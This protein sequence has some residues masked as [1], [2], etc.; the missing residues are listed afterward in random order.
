VRELSLKDVLD[1]LKTVFSTATED[2]KN[3]RTTAQWLLVLYHCLN[4]YSLQQEEQLLKQLKQL[5]FIPI[6]RYGKKEMVSL[7]KCN[8]FFPTSK[9]VNPTIK[10]SKNKIFSLIERELNLLDVESLLCLDQLKN[11]QVV[12]L[13]KNLGVKQIEPKEVIE[14]HIIDAFM[15]NQSSEE[16]LILY[17]IYI[18]ECFNSLSQSNLDTL[19]DHMLLMTNKG[20]KRLSETIFLTPTYGNKYDLKLIFPS[21]DWCLIDSIYFKRSIELKSADIDTCES[22]SKTKQNKQQQHQQNLNTKTDQNQFML[23]W[24]K[25]LICLG[26]TDIFTPK[27]VQKKLKSSELNDTIYSAHAELLPIITDDE[28]YVFNDFE[29]HVFSYYMSLVDKIDN[30]VPRPLIEQLT[31]LYR[32]IEENWDLGFKLN[33][34]KYVSVHVE[35]IKQQTQSKILNGSKFVKERFCETIY[36][37]NLKTKKWICA[38]SSEYSDV[39]ALTT[40]IILASPSDCFVKEQVFLRIYGVHLV[41]YAHTSP[42]N[43]DDPYSLSRDLKFKFE[44]EI[45]EFL[46]LFKKWI[47]SQTFFYASIAQMKNIYTQISA[48]LNSYDTKQEIHEACVELVNRKLQPIIFVPNDLNTTMDTKTAENVVKGS[49]Y[50]PLKSNVYW[51]DPENIFIK[52]KSSYLKMP[53]F[54]EN[55]Y[56]IKND[57]LKF[58]LI[59]DF[60]I[61]ESPSFE[62]YV[63]LL[64]HVA[65]LASTNKSPYSYRKTLGDVYQLYEILIVKCSISEEAVQQLYDRVKDK[66][67]IPW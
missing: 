53:I 61:L 5:E 51:S 48:Q 10:H 38:E 62:E 16:T 27:P 66:P 67:I 43:K 56:N 15:K 12:S 23:S 55:Y 39:Q 11:A 13:L 36:F 26:L 40:R 2:F 17:I 65:L 45:A 22:P 63:E 41:W 14:F 42:R 21:Y 58:M 1:I 24:R 8:V 46:S 7:E 3:I 4:N 37:R 52:Y 33:T 9:L 47:N 57:Q 25:F 34:F 29:C 60:G 18:H 6:L 35:F 64:E 20:L 50:P 49:F 31:N 30:D 44:F 59:N 32:I 19:K 54:L 28:C